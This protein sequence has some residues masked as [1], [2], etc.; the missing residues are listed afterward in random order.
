MGV[1]L[2]DRIR[3]LTPEQRRTF[4]ALLEPGLLAA[5]RYS[6]AFHARLPEQALPPP[7]ELASIE[8][9]IGGR[10]VGKTWWASML[11]NRE[12]LSGRAGDD[13]RIIA[14]TEAA[15]LDTVIDGPSGVRTWLPPHLKPDFVRS[16]GHAGTLIYPNGMRV[17][18]ISAEKPGSAVGQGKRITLADDPAAWSRVCGEPR[19]AEMF[20]EAR[21][22]TSEGPNPCTIVPTTLDGVG[23]LRR[24]LG[25][26]MVGVRKRNLGA[27]S[28]NTSLSAQFMATIAD[29]RESDGD[30][31][32]VALDGEEREDTVGAL[33]RRSW[34][35]AHRV[36]AAPDLA[37][38]VVS[39]DPA[40]D[41]KAG[42]DETG[43]VVVGQGHDGRLYVLADLTA[44]HPTALWPAIVAHAFAAYQ[45]DAIV[46]E[47]NRA[48]GLV[49]R[50]LAI[51]APHVPIVEVMAT[52]GKATRAEPLSLLY[53]DGQVSHLVDGP[54]LSHAGAVH[55]Q[56]QTFD[57]TSSTRQEVQ[58]EVQRD[59]RRWTTLEDELCG[60][61]PRG[62]RSPNGLDALVWGAWYL[63]PPDGCGEWT[64]SV[65]AAPRFG[66]AD[67]RAALPPAADPRRPTRM[68][69]LRR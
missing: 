30:W 24:A 32:A 45:A 60:W 35:D 41:D 58:V 46:A 31:A 28:S 27:T 42:S 56:V 3:A 64:P 68:G 8:L 4:Y 59:R 38:V 6:H 12:V 22:S 67:P 5:Q 52:R 14:S 18:C 54:Q 66:A 63:R 50:L 62:S 65:P 48:A 20:R 13:G 36:Q 51:E 17:V 33:W 37:R 53:R 61:T 29:L 10:R 16:R 15:V 26:S 21:L 1:S 47:T 25:G 7:G 9:V 23:F 40:D 55:L 39:V 43:I 49:R 44:R 69:M 2:A 11:F 57:A 34:I 19:A